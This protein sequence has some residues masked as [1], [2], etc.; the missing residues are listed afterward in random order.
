MPL[1]VR[2][3]RGGWWPDLRLSCQESP[4]NQLAE[5]QSAAG[6]LDT[7][8]HVPAIP[9]AAAVGQILGRRAGLALDFKD[10]QWALDQSAAVDA[11]GELFEHHVRLTAHATLAIACDD[12]AEQIHTRHIEVAITETNN[13][14]AG[15]VRPSSG[16]VSHHRR[17]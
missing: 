6:F 4:G 10:E 12:G 17:S 8:I 9:V 5:Y 3:A 7:T 1:P 11:V 14:W 2:S 16:R 13:G 15:V